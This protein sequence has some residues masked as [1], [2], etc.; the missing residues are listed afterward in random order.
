MTCEQIDRFLDQQWSSGDRAVPQQVA[1]HLQQCEPCRQLFRLVRRT[2]PD[3]QVPPE[4]QARLTEAVLQ[5]LEPV[6]P[7]GRRRFTLDLLGAFLVI[8]LLGIAVAGIRSPWVMSAGQFLTVTLVLAAGAIVLA[9]SLARQV[10]PGS[11]HKV[12]PGVLLAAI[13]AAFAGSLLLLFP[14]DMSGRFW[15]R[16][17]LC[18]S[19]GAVLAC[20]ATVPLWM[21]VRRGAL[22]SPALTGASTGLLAGVLSAVVIHLGCPMATAPHLAIWHAAVPVFSAFA[23]FLVGHFSS[24]HPAGSCRPRA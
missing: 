9:L 19:F 15:F 24:H 1:E 17:L 20:V 21:I 3:W 13:A 5:S 11:S 18:F 23:G 10:M 16:G 6:L 22:L 8:L 2:A 7:L 14:W 4:S 12:K